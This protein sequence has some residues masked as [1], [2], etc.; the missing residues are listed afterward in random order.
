MARGCSFIMQAK[1]LIHRC[2]LGIL[3]IVELRISG[4]KVEAMA[5]KLSMD[6]CFRRDQNGFLGGLQFLWNKN[7]FNV[8]IIKG[9][10]TTYTC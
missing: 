9:H 10:C 2:A 1:Y 4:N 3:V 8:N 6:G 5:R 7:I